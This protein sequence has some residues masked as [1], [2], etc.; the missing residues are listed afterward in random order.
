M[1]KGNFICRNKYYGRGLTADGFNEAIYQFFHNGSELKT[2]ILVP[3]IQRLE[4]LHAIIEKQEAFRFY[5]SSLLIMYEGNDTNDT[6]PEEDDD[7][8]PSASTVRESD[9][10]S[11][12]VTSKSSADPLVE[13]K[14]ID[15]A[16]STHRGFEDDS[17]IHN[18]PD[19][20][21]LFGL[22]HLINLFKKLLL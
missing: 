5:S 2:D 21:Y 12:H 8:P 9:N 3:I 1:D 4:Q 18:G 15:F 6:L 22:E 17:T 10:K 13:V 7:Q 16:H 20:G 19:Q 11:H 14:M